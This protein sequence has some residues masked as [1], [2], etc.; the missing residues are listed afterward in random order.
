MDASAIQSLISTV[1]FPI[2]VSIW[3]LYKGSKDSETLAKNQSE[4]TNAINI[5]RVS[6]ESLTSLLGK[7]SK[8]G[9]GNE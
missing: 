8:G 3:M 9:T 2:F 6:V 4:M 1:G 5:L 7:D